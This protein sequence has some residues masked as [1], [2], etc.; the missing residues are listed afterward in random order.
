MLKISSS[1]YQIDFEK[2]DNKS[3]SIRFDNLKIIIKYRLNIYLFLRYLCLLLVVF[4]FLAF[5]IFFVLL[6]VNLISGDSLK[7]K[8]TDLNRLF[9][10]NIVSN[11][12][13]C[14][15][16]YISIALC[17]V[18]WIAY[19][20]AREIQFYT[21]LRQH[22]IVTSQQSDLFDITV[23]ITDIL[24]YLRDISKLK[25]LYSV[26]SD[27]VFNV[28]LNRKYNSLLTKIDRQNQLI[29]ELENIE[30][31]L[32]CRANLRWQKYILVNNYL[33]NNSNFLK[34]EFIF[35][36]FVK[37]SNCKTI[38][39][40]RFFWIFFV[41]LVVDFENVINYCRTEVDF[42]NR[43]IFQKK[44]NLKTFDIVSFVFVQFYELR[45][46]YIV[47]Q[48]ILH[49]QSCTI[50]ASYIPEAVSQIVWKYIIL[51]W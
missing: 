41:L 9:W 7:N 10:I 28:I 5:L 38:V 36:E 19:I 12:T 50:I 15:W 37:F 6:F 32:I 22:S 1:R 14:Y 27:S 51:N 31:R 39:K 49:S 3:V 43:S 2:T 20:F 34:T 46:V 48:C 16:I 45:D 11:Y 26:Y 4:V 18:F 40:L 29:G 44:T 30:T 47:S 25:T 21:R 13:I 17:V 33:Y 8:I 42:L 24:L 35:P 23:L